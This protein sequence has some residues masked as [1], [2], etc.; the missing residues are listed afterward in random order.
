MEAERAPLERRCSCLPNAALWKCLF[1]NAFFFSADFI[2]CSVKLPRRVHCWEAEA[3][4]LHS[5]ISRP[6]LQ[7]I[8][9]RAKIG[10]KL[11]CLF[12]ELVRN[13]QNYTHHG[14][15]KQD[16]WTIWQNS[17]AKTLIFGFYSSA[18]ELHL[19]TAQQTKQQR[20]PEIERH[21]LAPIVSRLLPTMPF[22]T[23]ANTNTPI[24]TYNQHVFIWRLQGWQTGEWRLQ[25]YTRCQ[26]DPHQTPYLKISL[27]M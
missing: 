6:S 5:H 13:K 4:S 20:Q 10:E 3:L 11:H 19:R 8:I 15:I 23:A 18:A 7:K 26:T 21:V 27:Q 12:L 17:H 22:D 1:L 16:K 9:G 14:V 24:R 2:L 25:S